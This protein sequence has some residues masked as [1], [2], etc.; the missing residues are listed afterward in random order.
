M[1][2]FVKKIDFFFFG[3]CRCQQVS[4]FLTY[5]SIKL[6]V[7]HHLS[8]N[9]KYLRAAR[10]LSQQELADLLEVGRTA[11]ANYE[12][13]IANPGHKTLLALVNIFGIS[14]DEL[15]YQDLQETGIN[16]KEFQPVVVTVD[17][18]GQENIVLVDTKAAAGYPT[19][20]LEPE[21]YKELPAFQLPG[22][23][24]RNG[25]FRCFE[26]EGDSMNDTL[27]S[28]DYVIGRF[29]DNHY[30][31]V[32]EGYVHVVV[33]GDQVLVKRVINKAEQESKLILL[34][35]N[36]VYPPIEAGLD[37]V[38]EIWQVKSKLSSYLPVK[39]NDLDRLIGDLTSEIRMLKQR[40][41]DMQR[42][43][44]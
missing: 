14:L 18:S 10:K 40:V 32:R 29:C 35:D 1:T 21:Y 25:T 41:D 20:Y 22:A 26:V 16:R 23:D 34:S 39:R 24:Y 15:L 43:E 33:T 2:F 8:S 27:Q 30:K 6:T 5:K 11:I 3:Y 28:G 38:K 36:D 13:G 37:E 12:S 7:M 44:A 17:K 4:I 31:D 9:L 19:R 42:G